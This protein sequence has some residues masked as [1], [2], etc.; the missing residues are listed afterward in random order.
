[1]K[2]NVFQ[3]DLTDIS[4]KKEPLLAGLSEIS[5]V[6]PWGAGGRERYCPAESRYLARK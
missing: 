5:G 3:G 6:P 4:A 2:I 1:M